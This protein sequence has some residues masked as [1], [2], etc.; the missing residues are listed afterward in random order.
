MTAEP[1]DRYK[2]G[3]RATEGHRSRRGWPSPAIRPMATQRSRE[4]PNRSDSG[5]PPWSSALPPCWN[6]CDAA[7]RTIGATD[8]AGPR[9]PRSSRARSHITPGCP[10][11]PCDAGGACAAAIQ[12]IFQHGGRA[13][14]HGGPRESQRLVI[15]RD[16]TDGDAAEPRATQPLRL[17]WPSVVLRSSSVLESLRCRKQNDPCDG[18]RRAAPTAVIARPVAHADRRAQDG[19]GFITIPAS[20]PQSRNPR[21]IARPR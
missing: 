17:R 7:S 8:A 12:Q 11:E 20:L 16:P 15:A 3:R 6:R 2:E 10:S 13:E 19:T 9:Q 21:R 18:C 4:R 1:G 5:G 14:G